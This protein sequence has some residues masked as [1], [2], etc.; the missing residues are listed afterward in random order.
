MSDPLSTA[1]RLFG[2]RIRRLR[3]DLGWTQ[4]QLAEV[5]GMHYTYIGQAERGERN[6]SLRN[7]LRLA[8]ALK[9]DPGDLVTGLSEF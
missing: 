5:V 2:E 9:T 4:E 6:V 7:I 3:K 1:T 8:Y